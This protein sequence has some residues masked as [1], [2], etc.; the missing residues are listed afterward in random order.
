MPKPHPESDSDLIARLAALV[1]EPPQGRGR[2]SRL[3][4]WLTRHKDAFAGLV[5]VPEPNWDA[6]ARE[7]GNA[8]VVD[9]RGNPPTGIRLRKSWWAVNRQKPSKRGTQAA[10]QKAEPEPP[11]PSPTVQPPQPADEPE[12][13]P[14]KFKR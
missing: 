12:F 6:L 10:T 13:G 3:T 5:S 9:G 8:G 1:D 7:L 11:K 14:V 4:R 2:R